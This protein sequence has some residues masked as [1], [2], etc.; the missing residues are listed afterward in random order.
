M[1]VKAYKIS[2]G[3]KRVELDYNPM[4]KQGQAHQLV[5][6]YRGFCGG[7]GNGKTSFGCAETFTRLHEYPGT[8]AIVARKTRPEL[9]STTWDMLVNGDPGTPGAWTG[10][11][12]ETIASINKADMIITFRNK[13]VIY[14][15]PLDDP[16][17]IE[18]YNLGFFWVDQAEEIEEDIFLKFHGRLRQR[19]GPREGVLTFNPNGHNWLWHR[20]INPARP[21]RWNKFYKC[22]E[23]TTFDNVNLPDDYLEQ[24]EGLP[25]AWIQRYIHGSH[26][27]FVG[28][29]FTDWNPEI[30]VIQPFRLPM[31]WERWFCMDPGIRHEAAAS[32]MARDPLDNWY[33]YREHLEPNQDV[34]WW[35]KKIIA[36]EAEDDFGGPHESIHRRL[37]GPESQQRSQ[38]DGKTVLDIFNE[39][40]IY[41]EV[42]DRSPAA[43]ISRITELLRPKGGHRNPFTGATPGPRL[44]VFDTCDKMKRYLPQYR[45]VPVRVSYTEEDS[46]ERPRKKDDHNIDNCG[47]IVVAADR[48]VKED[49]GRR[50]YENSEQR[51][52]RELDEAAYMEAEQQKRGRHYHPE[53][54]RVA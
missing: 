4:A 43:R 27:V 10:I 1:P 45:W 9:K 15:L 36:M 3:T 38:T 49:D 40:G 5:A 32:W 21:L 46:P 39:N 54:G 37:I 29:I 13:S 6:K 8:R 16:A 12:K 48:Q 23:A 17:K 28:Q 44:Y 41:P 18:N 51:V 25:E 19:I 53:L 52:K 50:P 24:F 33:Y 11:P 26:E 20:F 7:W 34:A 42:A 14:G 47:H 2:R 31:H 30:H 22:I 35:S